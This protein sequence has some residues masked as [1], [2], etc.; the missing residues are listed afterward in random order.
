MIDIKAIDKLPADMRVP[1]MSLLQEV[2]EGT[3]R[4][5]IA[6]V[7]RTLGEQARAEAERAQKADEEAKRQR[8]EIWEILREAAALSKEGLSQIAALDKSV[9]E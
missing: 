3:R 9:P 2:R 4:E 7:E 8:D 1:I 6:E 5:V